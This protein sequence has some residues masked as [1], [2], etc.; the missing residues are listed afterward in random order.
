MKIG[1]I[2]HKVHRHGGM[3]RAGAEVLE[4]IARQHKVVVIARQCDIRGENIT[5][6][7]VHPLPR[8]NALL[9]WSFQREA[10][11]VEGDIDL[12]LTNAVGASA[13]EADVITAQFCHAAFHANHGTL[14][15]G[16]SRSRR[17][18]QAVAEKIFTRQEMRAYTSPRLKR[19]IAVSQGMKRE[20]ITY[21]GVDERKIT[22]IPNGVDHQT[23]SPEKD[24]EAKRALRRQ[25]GLPEDNFLCLFV[26][27]DWDRKGLADAVGAVA[28]LP[29][30]SLIVVGSGD[31]DRYRK[32]A[33]AVGAEH[34]IIFAGQ[35]LRSHDYYRAADIF[36]FPSRYEAFSLVTIEAAASG[37]PILALR[38][39]GTEELIEEGSNGYFVEGSPVSIREKIELLSQNRPLLTEMSEAALESSRRYTWDRVASE[40]LEVFESVLGHR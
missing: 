14:R 28:G 24:P 3:E 15:G 22:V 7:P 33:Q 36:V 21:Y 35:S 18:Y 25:L 10:Q 6:A 37:L 19:V 31:V 27:G 5:F 34:Q 8:P 29:K 4:R 9:S 1:Y 39:N 17:I 12:D 23:F 38:I 32:L 40:Q 30:T 26:G 2:A 11:R 13:R 20:L 16:S